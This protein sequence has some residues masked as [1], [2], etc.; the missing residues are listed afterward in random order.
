MAKRKHFT[1]NNLTF[2]T[3]QISDKVKAIKESLSGGVVVTFG[4]E[5]FEFMLELFHK[6]YPFR[7]TKVIDP[8]AVRDLT[9]D[10]NENCK[11]RSE[12]FFWVMHN[13]D[14]V[15]WQPKDCWAPM[16][17][18]TSVIQAFRNAISDQSSNEFE[19]LKKQANGRLVECAIT[20]KLFD[21]LQPG[22]CE[23]DHAAPEFEMIFWAFIGKTG[24]DIGSVQFYRDNGCYLSD[25]KLESEFKEFHA[26]HAN[27]V[28]ISKDGHKIKTYSQ[29]QL[30]KYKFA[31]RNEYLN[32]LGV[33]NG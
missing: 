23:V 18:N 31:T 24:T 5:R 4:E 32:L 2:T 13:G 27:L 6:Y 15:N 9:V 21:P 22:Q 12:T 20:E 26:K 14:M 11:Y 29:K 1:I 7:E 19:R 33:V 28:V 8:H 3:Q 30:A 25:S 10:R 17:H 16:S